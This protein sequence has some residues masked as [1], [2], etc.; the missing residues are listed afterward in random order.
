MNMTRT[1]RLKHAL[2]EIKRAEQSVNFMLSTNP[3]KEITPACVRL[4]DET[5]E[6]LR[7]AQSE[8]RYQ[9]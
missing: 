9:R 5:R 2:I 7:K 8:I 6:T 1:E 4:I 3:E